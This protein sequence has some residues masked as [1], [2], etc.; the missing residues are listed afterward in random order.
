MA[1]Q[2]LKGAKTCGFTEVDLVELDSVVV[3]RRV[4]FEEVALAD[5]TTS[6]SNH[7]TL[8]SAGK[9]LL[10]IVRCRNLYFYLDQKKIG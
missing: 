2:V 1:E 6:R 9:L 7:A 3:H 4:S 8:L 5:A 10:H